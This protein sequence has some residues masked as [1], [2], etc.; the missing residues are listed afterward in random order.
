VIITDTFGRV[1]RNGLTNVAIGVAG[2]APLQSFAGQQDPFGY[3]LRVTVM[4]VADELAGAA[5]LVM[6]KTDGVPFA[7]V[8][9]FPYEA[10]DGSARELVRDAALD[11]FR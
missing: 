5:E 11:L 10:R 6:G 7:L 3:E 9:G 8:R 1:W 4:A 2:M